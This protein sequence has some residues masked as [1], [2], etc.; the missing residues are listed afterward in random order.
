MAVSES[1][2]PMRLEE[3]VQFFERQFG[4][5]EAGDS[6]IARDG[7]PFVTIVC[8]GVKLEGQP[9]GCYAATPEI[10]AAMWL[11]AAVAYANSRGGSTLIWRH[12]PELAG[13]EKGGLCVWALEQVCNPMPFGVPFEIRP[14]Y[15]VYSR[16]YVTKG[17]ADG[18]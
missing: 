7:H 5:V 14:L 9:F 16:M 12:E 4:N 17:D 13:P 15:Q 1:P 6:A 10:A 3:A 8:G 18:A 2:T 11:D